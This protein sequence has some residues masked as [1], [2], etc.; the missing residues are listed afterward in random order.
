M[1]TSVT[2]PLVDGKGSIFPSGSLAQ[3]NA[4]HFDYQ[5]K[6]ESCFKSEG[7]YPDFDFVMN[8]FGGYIPE[9]D[10]KNYSNIIFVNGEYDPWL[11]GCV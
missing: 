4:I 7:F 5:R 3:Q 10:F 11:C 9:R 1:C 8:E 2:M 6:K